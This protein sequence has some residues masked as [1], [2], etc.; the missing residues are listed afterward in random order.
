MT[1]RKITLDGAVR[2]VERGAGLAELGD[3]LLE[4][5]PD[6]VNALERTVGLNTMA[7]GA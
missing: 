1:S 6:R 2:H 7:P 5:R 4:E 3:Q